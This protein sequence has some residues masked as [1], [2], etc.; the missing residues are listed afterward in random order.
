VPINESWG[1]P[2]LQTDSRQPN[3][4]RALVYLIRSLDATRPV[5][6]NDGWEHTDSDLC[7]IHDYSD[8]N[9]VLRQRYATVESAVTSRPAKRPIYVDGFAY[10][11]EPIILS[12]FGGIAFKRSDQEGWGYTSAQTADEFR[13]RYAALMETVFAL[14]VIG[15]YCYTQF[16]DVE[17]EINGLLT[18]DRQPKIDLDVIRAINQRQPQPI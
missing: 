15:G 12:E 11:G 9:A 8:D 7:T 3:H 16:T 4:T 1:V 13:A 6:S 5:I 17:Q 10:Q 2:C 14:P 18:Y